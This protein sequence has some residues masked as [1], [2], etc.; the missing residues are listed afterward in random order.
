M[1]PLCMH[2]RGKIIFGIPEGDK[3]KVKFKCHD[4][5]REITKVVKRETL[6]KLEFIPDSK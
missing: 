4:C 2:K 1:K 6:H 3:A 5:G